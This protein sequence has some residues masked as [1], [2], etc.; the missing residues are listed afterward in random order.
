MDHGRFRNK[1]EEI[2]DLAWVNLNDT[3][4]QK[5]KALM[6]NVYYN[7]SEFAGIVVDDGNTV[8]DGFKNLAVFDS[9]Y[10]GINL[11]V[12][13]WKRLYEQEVK[14]LAA[15]GI[16]LKCNFQSSY[17]CFYEGPCQ[18]QQFA[19]F[20]FNFVGDRVYIIQP[21]DYLISTLNKNG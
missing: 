14:L 16:N 7:R 20:G 17:T 5:W 1:L 12:I 21:K 15:K 2:K 9:F 13:E 4:Q 19:A 10:P 6:H 18:P 3:N 11:P 8:D